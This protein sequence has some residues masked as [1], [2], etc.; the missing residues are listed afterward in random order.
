MAHRPYIETYRRA[1][2]DMHNLAAINVVADVAPGFVWR[3]QDEAG[4]ATGI[5][6]TDDDLSVINLSVWESVADLEAYVYHSVHRAPWRVVRSPRAGTY[7]D[8][9]ARGGAHPEHR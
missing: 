5:E 8:V 2:L 1:L 6:V 7:D 3:L 9:V 4:N